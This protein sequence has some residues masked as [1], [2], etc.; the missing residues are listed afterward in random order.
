M[1]TYFV[2]LTCRNAENLITSAILSII[3]QLVPPKYIIIINDGSTDNTKKLL[4]NISKDYD[5]IYIIN[6]P[7]WGYDVTRVVKNWNEALKLRSNLNLERTDYHMICTD[8]TIYPKDYAKKIITFLDSNLGISI[9]SGQHGKGISSLPHGAG[10]FV[11]T[12]FFEN[13][14]WNGYYPEKMGYESAILYES[15]RCGYK[16]DVLNDLKYHHKRPLGTNHK[17]YT[18]GASMNTL[19]YHPFY[20]YLR[21]LKNLITGS[22]TGRIGAFFM[23]FYYLTYKPKSSGFDSLFDLETRNFIRKFQIEKIKK[24][25]LRSE[26]N[27]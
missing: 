5:Y 18:F 23:L 11:R 7:D 14:R 4:E 8:D 16:N 10:R 25:I 20:V 22:E 27:I 1:G 9:C 26:K 21:F 17:F 13:T 6:H 12:S 3:N 24:M 2:I 19:G 15:L